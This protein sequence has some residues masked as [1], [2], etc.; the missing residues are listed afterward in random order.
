MELL[1]RQGVPERGIVIFMS[2][3]SVSILQNKDICLTNPF[4]GRLSRVIGHVHV[5]K[6]VSSVLRRGD[7]E[8]PCQVGLPDVPSLQILI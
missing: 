2:A 7:S 4:S 5:V 8:N 3:G 6:S 1:S